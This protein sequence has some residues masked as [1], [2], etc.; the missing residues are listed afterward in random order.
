MPDFTDGQIYVEY[1]HMANAADDMVFQTKA[2]G[3]TLESLEMELNELKKSWEGEDSSVYVTKQN[4]WDTAAR[5]M[6]HLLDNNRVLLTDISDQYQ[7]S[8]RM[9]A[10]MW[11]EVQIGR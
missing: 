10:Q 11:S 7:Y 6:Q 9:L 1:N 8:E 2:I 5:N 3:E 4:E